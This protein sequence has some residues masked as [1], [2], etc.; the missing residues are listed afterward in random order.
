MATKRI[1][2]TRLWAGHPAGEIV[3]E[4]DFTVDS[5]VRKGYGKELPAAGELEIPGN[6]PIETTMLTPPAET[7]AAGPQ[8]SKRKPKRGAPPAPT[9]DANPEL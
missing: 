3:E 6:P 2:L 7:A 5:M 8:A 4:Q 9:A 1:L